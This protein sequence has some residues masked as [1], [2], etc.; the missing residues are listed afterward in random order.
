[1]SRL[2]DEQARHDYG[3][4]KLKGF[5]LDIASV[6]G[7]QERKLMSFYDIKSLIKPRKE[8]YRGMQVVKIEDIVGS[9][10]RFEDFNKTFLPRRD[11]LKQRWMNVDKAYHKDIVL[12]PILLYK[13][14]DVYFVRDGNHR[15]SME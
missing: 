10:G 7:G 12:P 4:A 1:M 5:Y 9:E 6:L 15:A 13:I 2:L 8:S 3:R 14:G 11:H